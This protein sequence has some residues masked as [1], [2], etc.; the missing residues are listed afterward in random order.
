[1]KRFHVLVR[2]TIREL[3]DQGERFP[4]LRTRRWPC[5]GTRGRIRG[6]L[7]VGGILLVSTPPDL[8][9]TWGSRRLEKLDGPSERAQAVSAVEG[10]QEPGGQ[11]QEVAEK[12]RDAFLLV[13]EVLEEAKRISDPAQRWRIRLQAADLLWTLDEPAGRSLCENLMDEIVRME[14]K[15]ERGGRERP[16]NVGLR[17]ALF[18]ELLHVV[19]RR[20]SRFAA[21]L[22]ERLTDEEAERA[23]GGLTRAALYQEML[24]ALWDA[25]AG[26]VSREVSLLTDVLGRVLSPGGEI[27]PL[28]SVL[29]TSAASSPEAGDALFR[30][31]FSR[32]PMLSQDSALAVLG[33]YLSRRFRT[34]DSLAPLEREAQ[35]IFAHVL[36]RA[37]ML[38]QQ[39]RAGRAFSGSRETRRFI[40]SLTHDYLP[41]FQK[42]GDPAQVAQ[43]TV[44]AQTLLGAL[45]DEQRSVSPPG[46]A[47]GTL[48]EE[49]QAIEREP[50][51]RV[52][53]QRLRE[54]A[55]RVPPE[56]ARKAAEKISD[57]RMREVTL[58]EVKIRQTMEQTARRQFEEAQQVAATLGDAGRRAR[59]FIEIA[60]ALLN[61]RQIESG[62]AL[63]ERAVQ[64]AMR[65][66]RTPRRA[67]CFFDVAGLLAPLDATRAFHILMEAIQAANE[68][69]PEEKVNVRD[70]VFGGV[71]FTP[72]KLSLTYRPEI[73]EIELPAELLLL[74]R[75]DPYMVRLVSWRIRSPL[76]RS[77]F[78]LLLARALVEDVRKTGG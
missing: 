7:V 37:E 62:R 53:D 50:R 11:E 14:V 65:A 32:L 74:A 45:P 31:V 30:V 59:A 48:E 66:A 4:D 69:G 71:L 17:R 26:D 24:A 51:A 57:I 54:L 41:L 64:E 56:Q 42:F 47:G 46:V 55:L 29:L 5:R 40:V 19:I 34:A 28:V 68:A 58:E 2:Q 1:M 72:G 20:D 36:A 73:E 23:T 70:E 63:L 3:R 75:E 6:A 38:W 76:L 15:E 77:R 25:S 9:I 52:R 43:L 35:A 39:A 61:D 49:L 21:R 78:L 13:Q 16:A 22:I 67:E 44:Y 33:A 60:R 12:R 8:Q 27:P 18:R 10:R